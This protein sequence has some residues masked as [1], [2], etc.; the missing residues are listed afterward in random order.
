MINWGGGT[1]VKSGGGTKLSDSLYINVDLTVIFFYYPAS[2]DF[3]V[4]FI[5]E[6]FLFFLVN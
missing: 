1:G 5:L 3:D 2:C 4:I 6:I